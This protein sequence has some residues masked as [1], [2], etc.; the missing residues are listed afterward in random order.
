MG[1]TH[2]GVTKTRKPD[3]QEG[4]WDIP[5]NEN[6]ELMGTVL[7]TL[8]TGNRVVSGFALTEDGG[9]NFT[10]AAGVIHRGGAEENILGGSFLAQNGTTVYVFVDNVG[11][12]VVGNTYSVSNPVPLFIIQASGSQIVSV[13][14][15]RHKQVA[16]AGGG[17]GLEWEIIT[18]A[19][20]GEAN[21]GYFCDLAA[22]PFTV[23]LPLDPEIGQMMG[24]NDFKGA[25]SLYN[26]TIGANGM[27][28][29]S[30]V[31][32]LVI[33]TRFRNLVL[34]YSDATEGW[35]VTTM[36]DHAYPNQNV[37][38]GLGAPPSDLGIDGDLYFEY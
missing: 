26:L 5:L 4:R 35:R 18:G 30:N 14:D 2:L 31:E 29:M 28:I 24:V 6:W 38:A 33:N 34:T 20:D 10:I 23:K 1:I 22:G 16:G 13:G 7:E 32:D 15:L 17:A 36:V 19:H 21:K 37:Y 3:Y 9:L 8:V 27:P 25:A 12:I 11:N